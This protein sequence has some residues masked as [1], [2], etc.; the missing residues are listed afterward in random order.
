MRL[1]G[2]IQKWVDHSISV[3]V[4]LPETAT[5]ELVDRL[6][7]EA[8]KVGCKGVTIYRAGSRGNVLEDVSKSKKSEKE[9]AQTAHTAK[10]QICF[11]VTDMLKRP[12]ELDCEILRFQN[13]KVH[14]E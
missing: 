9:S 6:Y 10:E 3:T 13:Q 5:E 2:R 14:M 11:P 1:Q 8:W 7:R 12:K 4:N